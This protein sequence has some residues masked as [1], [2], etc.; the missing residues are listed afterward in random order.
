MKSIIS[1][2]LVLGMI[3]GNVA[4]AGPFVSIE[5]K[6]K[7]VGDD[8]TGAA[9]EVHGGYTWDNGI[10]LQGGPVFLSPDG[11]EGSTEYSAKVKYT[12]YLSEEVKLYGEISAQTVDK[13]LSFDT[14][15]FGTKI[16]VVY[17]F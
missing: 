10:T 1:T 4:V 3:H 17:S 2:G 12:T 15:G 8:F 7:F 11:E 14:M 6:S 9:T 16:G 5:N 13:E